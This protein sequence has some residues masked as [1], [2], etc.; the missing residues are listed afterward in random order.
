MQHQTN[1]P[2]QPQNTRPPTPCL[3]ALQAK[4]TKL[5]FTHFFFFF[6]GFYLTLLAKLVS[7]TLANFG[8]P[9]S[10]QIF[11][12]SLLRDWRLKDLFDLV[13]SAELTRS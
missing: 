5:T 13:P 1:Q 4:L 6:W 8:P 2:C 10:P 3:G 9:G 7:P 11:S 12:L